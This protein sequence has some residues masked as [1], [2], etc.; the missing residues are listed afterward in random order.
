[1][2]ARVEC[3]STFGGGSMPG[4]TLQSVGVQIDV[5]G[6]RAD[7]IDRALTANEVPIVGF[8]ADGKYTLDFRTVLEEDIP[9]IVQA[10]T[11]LFSGA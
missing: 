10:L 7:D 11:A 9:V 1:M 4:Y 8:I 6:L 3:K 5:P 2:V